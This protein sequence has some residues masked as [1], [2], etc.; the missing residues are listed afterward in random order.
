M[1]FGQRSFVIIYFKVTVL[2]NSLIIN[3]LDVSSPAS[4]RELRVNMFQ[5]VRMDSGTLEPQMSCSSIPVSS[6]GS[7]PIKTHRSS[8][9]SIS[10]W[11]PSLGQSP[12][13][14]SALHTPSHWPAP[15]LSS[16]CS[17]QG[18]WIPPA[19]LDYTRQAP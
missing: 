5:A 19:Q 10:A 4:K 9:A 1:M 8:S 13:S 3:S 12:R 15:T 6:A 16:C 14:S 17:V 18:L 11:S 2:K 7:L